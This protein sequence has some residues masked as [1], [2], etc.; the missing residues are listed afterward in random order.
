MRRAARCA[1]LTYATA[2][3][4]VRE[5]GARVAL[6]PVGFAGAAKEELAFLHEKLIELLLEFADICRKHDIEWCTA[7]RRP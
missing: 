6:N 3:A 2:C 5:I 4:V 7:A 1:P